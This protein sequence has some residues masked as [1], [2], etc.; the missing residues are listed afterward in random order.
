MK[1]LN[2]LAYVLAE[3]LRGA[4]TANVEVNVGDGNL[5]IDRLTGG[6]QLLASGTLQY[7][8]N[9]GAPNRYASVDN[10]HARLTLRGGAASRPKFRMPWDAC[11]G[12][13]DWQIHLN[14]G[15]QSD[16][17]AHSDG[18]NVKVD[19]AG[20]AVIRLT[21]DTGGGNMDVVLPD[22]AANL[23]V[24]ART[25]AGNVTVKVGSGITGSNT[26]E[27]K[28]GAG[29]AIVRV[30]NGIEARVHATSGLGVVTVDSQFSKID[31]STYQSPGY[32]GA[33]NKV[34]ISV[35]SGAGNVSVSTK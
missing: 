3:P 32:D 12:A 1:T 16:I 4:K 33:A 30:P 14:P 19:L 28:S 21:A 25:G 34:E 35:H 24:A 29:N 8:E 26:V 15:V 7:L 10:G 22:N 20:M 18:G 17:T 23:S 5:T 27:A 11:N 2:A 31:A 6:E 9:Q 13:T